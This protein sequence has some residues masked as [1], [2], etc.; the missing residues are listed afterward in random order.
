MHQ[1]HIQIQIQL[2]PTKRHPCI[3][4]GKGV[5]WP[6]RGSRMWHQRLNSI[7]KSVL[8]DGGSVR[9]AE[10]SN[11]PHPDDRPQCC[12]GVISKFEIIPKRSTLWSDF[13]RVTQTWPCASRRSIEALIEAGHLR[14][15]DYQQFNPILTSPCA[16]WPAEGKRQACSA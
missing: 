4:Y 12:S 16:H 2:M 13:L 10:K 6:G 14:F 15:C 5:V 9:Q 1:V 7:W 11:Q 3:V 8:P